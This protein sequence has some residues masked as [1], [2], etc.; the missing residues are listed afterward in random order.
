[1]IFIKSI[2]AAALVFLFRDININ[3]ILAKR[4][5][6]LHKIDLSELIYKMWQKIV[7]SELISKHSFDVVNQALIISKFRINV[8]KTLFA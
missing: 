4:M 7:L 6:V 8:K 5:W 2:T 3:I 1:M